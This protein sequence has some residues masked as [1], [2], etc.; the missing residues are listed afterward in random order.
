MYY[1]LEDIKRDIKELSAKDFYTKY[2][3]RSENWYIE[4]YLE[5]ED[6]SYFLDQYRLIVSEALGV[7]FNSVMMV[8][9][10]KLGYSLSLEM[11]GNE[12]KLFKEFEVTGEKRKPSDIDIAI[13]S[14]DIF[15]YYWRLFRREYSITNAV[16]YPRLAKEIYRGYINEKSITDNDA[17]RSEWVEKTKM[18]NER[19]MSDLY[20]KQEVTY[21][22]YRSWEDF[23]EYN[24]NSIKKIKEIMG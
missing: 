10:G 16:I 1:K 7:S 12:S 5:K 11:C 24:I 14:N 21:R 18:A 3:V 19:L 2:I 13:I 15:S 22:I 6:V 20:F 23:E 9:S 8:G 4:K 17:C